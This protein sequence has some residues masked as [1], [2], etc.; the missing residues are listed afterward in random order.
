MSVDPTSYELTQQVGPKLTGKSEPTKALRGVVPGLTSGPHPLSVAH[1]KVPPF[2]CVATPDKPSLTHFCDICKSWLFNCRHAG[3]QVDEQTGPLAVCISVSQGKRVMGPYHFCKYC[4]KPLIAF[5]G[6]E[7][8]S[9][10]AGP[11]KELTKIVFEKGSA[12]TATTDGSGDVVK[13]NEESVVAKVQ[14]QLTGG[15][16]RRVAK[17]TSKKTSKKDSRKKLSRS[18]DKNTKKGSKKGSKKSS[19][20]GSKGSKKRH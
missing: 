17:K 10:Q 19:K 12:K 3:A 7:S 4:K 11:H 20:K 13:A 14:P 8:V 16:R 15:A 1:P 5:N 18:Q 6:E 9:S 2:E